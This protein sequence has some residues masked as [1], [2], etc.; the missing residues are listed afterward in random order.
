[1]QFLC[2]KHSSR[3]DRNVLRKNRSKEAGLTLIEVMIAATVMVFAISSSL[4]VL[5]Q[6][7]RALDTARLKTLAGQ[8]LQGQ[9]ERIRMLTWTQLTD[10]TYGPGFYATFTPPPDI[11]SAAAAQVS[12][13]K[14]NGAPGE[15]RQTITTPSGAFSTQMRI[16]T[17]TASWNGIDGQP[18]TLSY[19]SH[20]AKNGLSD[21]FYTSR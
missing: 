6:G 4:I 17:L 19:I 1:M 2:V 18:H 21:F 8:I 20:Y 11:T 10:P 12:R 7:L 13:F 3:A 5:Q 9:M 15:F 16:I 14:V